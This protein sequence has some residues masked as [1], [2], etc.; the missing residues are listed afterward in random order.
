MPVQDCI[1]PLPI[2]LFPI[3]AIRPVQNLTA[4]TK[5]NFTFAIPPINLC[6]VRPVQHISDCATVHVKFTYTSKPPMCTT[7]GIEPQ[8][9]YN[10]AL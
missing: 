3:L 9:L 2:T 6:A 5:V 8:R 1:L 7:A 10:G 4:C